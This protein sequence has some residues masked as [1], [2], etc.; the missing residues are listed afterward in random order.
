MVTEVNITRKENY[1]RKT[2]LFKEKTKR[3]SFNLNDNSNAL[4]KQLIF[5]FFPPQF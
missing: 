1:I 5:S 3:N 2:I 4:N